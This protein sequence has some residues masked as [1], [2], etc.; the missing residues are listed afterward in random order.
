MVDP[1]QS[2]G[3]PKQQLQV[4]ARHPIIRRIFEVRR[5]GDE[6]LAREAVLQIFD[7]ALMQAGLIDD[8]RAMVPRIN[9]IL[10]R[11]LGTK[12]SSSQENEKI[13]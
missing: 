11:A 9:K 7:N 2:P 4:N 6:V 3:L 5:G 8:G 10:E 1:T 13:N 12:E